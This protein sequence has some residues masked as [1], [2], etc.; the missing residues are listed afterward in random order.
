MAE[1]DF[2]LHDNF[3]DQTEHLVRTTIKE[4]KGLSINRINCYC[5]GCD[6]LKR[7]IINK[8]GGRQVAVLPGN[9]FVS[10]KY[11][12]VLVYQFGECVHAKD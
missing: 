5:L 11:E 8:L 3:I 10:G 1:F 7:D 4:S 9:I 12:D 6:H 2:Y